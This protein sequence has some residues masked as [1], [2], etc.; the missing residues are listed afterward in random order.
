MIVALEKREQMTGDLWLLSLLITLIE[1]PGHSA[2]S[3]NSGRAQESPSLSW[4]SK[5]KQLE[6]PWWLIFRAE[7]QRDAQKTSLEACRKSCWRTH[8]VMT[9]VW[10]WEI[11]LRLGKE[12]NGRTEG[13]RA[14]PLTGSGTRSVLTARLGK[15][16]SSWGF[17]QNTLVFPH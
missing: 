10:L 3:K 15:P 11:H 17:E 6:R 7:Y 16:N 13:H 5:A 14:G 8:C 2:R 9:G 1:F 12:P 4:G